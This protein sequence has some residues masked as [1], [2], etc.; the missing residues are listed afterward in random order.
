LLHAYLNPLNPIYKN[1]I[2]FAKKNRMKRM[3]FHEEGQEQVG[4]LD[5]AVSFDQDPPAFINTDFMDDTEM[6]RWQRNISISFG[7]I[8]LAAT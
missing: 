1:R 5:N 7:K 4:Q 6:A 2:R 8:T 3:P